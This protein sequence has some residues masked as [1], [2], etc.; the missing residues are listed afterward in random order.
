[1]DFQLEEGGYIS[2]KVT[3]IGLNPIQDFMVGAY[4]EK[5]GGIWDGWTST[6]ENGNYRI[7]PL[8]PGDYFVL[9]CTSCNDLNY[10]QVWWDSSNGTFDCNNA[11][12]VTV[13]ANQTTNISD[14]KLIPGAIISGIVEDKDGNPITGESVYVNPQIGD[15]CGA[16]QGYGRCW[17]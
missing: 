5:C 3:D 6:D 17:N 9:A 10:V 7:G 16:Y 14:F 1:M 13:A 4:S 2:G 15:P 12:S 8:P 11:L